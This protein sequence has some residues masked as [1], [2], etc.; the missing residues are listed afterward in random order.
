MQTKRPASTHKMKAARLV[1]W[2]FESVSAALALY[3]LGGTGWL[4]KDMSKWIYQVYVPMGL[5]IWAL[6]SELR[7]SEGRGFSLPH[8]AT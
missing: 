5:P 2:F 6:V 1:A 7:L 4:L 8:L 3:G